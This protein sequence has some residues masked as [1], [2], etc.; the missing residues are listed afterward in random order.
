VLIASTGAFVGEKLK[1]GLKEPRFGTGDR[2]FDAFETATAIEPTVSVTTQS[3]E[4]TCSGFALPTLAS[5]A[6][7][8]ARQPHG[9]IEGDKL[10][11]GRVWLR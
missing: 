8:R 6:G 4:S 10:V 3:L 7:S 9:V 2:G 5:C 11:E 1:R